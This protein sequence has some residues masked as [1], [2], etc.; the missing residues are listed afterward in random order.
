MSTFIK[1][2][3]KQKKAVDHNQKINILIFR[4]SSPQIT[5]LTFSQNLKKHTF[6]I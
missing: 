3:E 2:P 4:A 6:S 1:K 5:F